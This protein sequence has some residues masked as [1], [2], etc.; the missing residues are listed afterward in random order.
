[1]LGE[2]ESARIFLILLTKQFLCFGGGI[3]PSPSIPLAF[4]CFSN[5]L[6]R[7]SISLQRFVPDLLGRCAYVSKSE[8]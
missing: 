5:S 7:L 2:P 4:L 3:E 8:P 1:M 6:Q